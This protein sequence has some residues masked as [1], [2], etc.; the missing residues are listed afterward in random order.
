MNVMLVKLQVITE[1]IL[2]QKWCFIIYLI[3]LFLLI[4]CVSIIF[5]ILISFVQKL[6][7]NV[8]NKKEQ[9]DR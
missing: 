4:M 1:F 8:H 3:R 5:R 6:S 7:N 2:L 9:I